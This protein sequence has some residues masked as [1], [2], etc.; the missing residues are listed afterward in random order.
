[1]LRI[2]F[3]FL[4]KPA[5]VDIHAS[6]GYESLRPPHAVKQLVP[7]EDTIG[8]YR[9]KVEEPELESAHWNGLASA[10][11]A[12]RGRINAES[13]NFKSFLGRGSRLGSP[14][15]RFYASDEFTRTERFGDVIVGAKFESH[16]A[17]RLLSLRRKN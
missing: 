6:R 2:D 17:V 13:T 5:D 7:R 4:T 8:P 10:R 12:V 14:Q 16:D 15:E 11:N 1:M 3:N 9:Q